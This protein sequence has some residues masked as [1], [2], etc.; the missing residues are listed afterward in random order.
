MNDAVIDRILAQRGDR[1]GRG[2]SHVPPAPPDQP[3]G[4]RAGGALD[5]LLAEGDLADDLGCF[6]WL[7]GV[8]ERAIMLELRKRSGD[9]LAL[10]YAWLESVA[11]DPSIGITLAFPGRRVFIKGR[12]LG[13]PV[14]PNVRLFDGVIRHRVPWIREMDT[15]ESTTVATV[16]QIVIE[17]IT[18]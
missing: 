5:A 6:G 13:A 3:P 4:L 8:R 14:R 16:D 2:A 9:V 15:A 10:G 12:N 7:R 17:S 1:P 18:W 11:F